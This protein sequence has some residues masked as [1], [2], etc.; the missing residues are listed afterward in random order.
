MLRLTIFFSG[1]LLFMEN[2]RF[3]IISLV[4]YYFCFDFGRVISWNL[5]IILFACLSAMCMI[6]VPFLS[7]VLCNYLIFSIFMH[8][9]SSPVTRRTFEPIISP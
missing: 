6:L 4:E 7:H 2:I 3:V 5:L 1:N 8:I 9:Q